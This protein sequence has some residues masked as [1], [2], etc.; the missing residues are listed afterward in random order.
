V[1]HW[2]VEGK[3]TSVRLPKDLEEAVRKDASEQNVSFNEL[4]KRV[5]TKFIEWD[6]HAER[7]GM[8]AIRREGLTKLFEAIPAAELKRI[9][10]SQAKTTTGEQLN[11][12]VGKSDVT[13]FVSFLELY[14]RYGG[15]GNFSADHHNSSI[16]IR[17]HH[18]LGLKGSVV[19][20]DWLGAFC[21]K[22]LGQV[23]QFSTGIN[24]ISGEIKLQNRKEDGSID[25][26][27]E[28]AGS[29]RIPR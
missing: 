2:D 21:E 24:S 6:G 7:F 15:L 13:S 12:W 28:A 14:S 9:S 17:L 3:M 4:V 16:T 19:I 18:Q 26:F 5:L 11:F 27:Y 23:V 29:P 10:E 8:L 25:R 20:A 1:R 22:I